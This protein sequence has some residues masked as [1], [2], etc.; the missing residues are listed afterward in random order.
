MSIPIID[1]FAGPGGLGEGFSSVRDASGG[2]AFRIGLSIEKEA[3]ACNTL[4]LRAAYRHLREGGQASTYFDFVRNDLTWD[5]FKTASGVKDALAAAAAEARQYELGKADEKVIDREIRSALGGREDWVLIGGPP[6]QAYSLVGRA[7]RANDESFA[8]DE[9]HFLYRE[10]LRIIREHRPAVFVM[11]NV[12]GLLSS[13]HSGER[14]FER[15]R[16][17]LARPLPD[18]E[19]EICSFVQGGS[20][21]ALQPYDYVIEAESYGIPQTRHRVILLGIRKGFV[22]APSSA[23]LMPS[24]KVSVFDAISNLPRIRSRLSRGNDSVDAWQAAVCKSPALL[25]GWRN[26]ERDKVCEL[27]E[28]AAQEAQKWTSTGAG[29]IPWKLPMPDTE[30]A[31][32]IHSQELGGVTLHDARSHMAPDLARYLFA[33]AFASRAG[34]SPRLRDF[35]PRL[36]PEH[37]S[38]VED[39]ESGVT[40]FQD[41]FRVQCRFGPSSTI[42]S[43]IAKD[44]HYYVHY[45][46]AQC[47]S[48]TVREAARLQTFP[49]DYFFRGNRTQQYTQVGN[50]VPPLLAVKLGRSVLGLMQQARKGQLALAA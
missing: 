9:K 3:S 44:G 20:S 21:D 33:A 16:G 38:A 32:W 30:Y 17:D 12:K 5:E 49:D 36:L 31:H 28:H 14:M 18:L 26:P 6:C 35:P 8:A 34:E 15:I 19:Y 46:P 47:R 13:R 40:A 2:T 43:H 25:R 37:R 24:P 27:M 10:Y 1:L 39:A 48:L 11:E 42:V 45:D 50:A 7:R 22:A 23:L 41:R 29:F 4:Q